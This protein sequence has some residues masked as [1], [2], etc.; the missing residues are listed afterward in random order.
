[1]HFDIPSIWHI[2]LIPPLREKSILV[3]RN[4]DD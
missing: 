3:T 2:A 1:M 4:F